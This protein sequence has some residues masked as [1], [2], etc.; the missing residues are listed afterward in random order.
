MLHLATMGVEVRSGWIKHGRTVHDGGIDEALLR[1][2]V[3]ARRHQ[4]GFHFLRI[5]RF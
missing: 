5:R 2:G 4:P 3:T 1:V